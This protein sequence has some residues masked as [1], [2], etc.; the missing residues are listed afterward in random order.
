MFLLAFKSA[1]VDSL[2]LL[3]SVRFVWVFG[4]ETAVLVICS[5]IKKRQLVL[6]QSVYGIWDRVG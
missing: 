2:S 4:P 5:F 3:F 6:V 1:Y